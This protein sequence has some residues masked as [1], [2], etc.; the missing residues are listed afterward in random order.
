MVYIIYKRIINFYFIFNSIL[1]LHDTIY[2]I[3]LFFI[4]FKYMSIYQKFIY[5]AYYFFFSFLIFNLT[6]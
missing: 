5:H 3:P 4:D 1:F 2:D 6:T